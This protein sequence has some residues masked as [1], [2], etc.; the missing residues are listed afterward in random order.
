MARFTTG[1][2]FTSTQQ[3]TAEALN[4]AVN[5]AAIST[6]SVDGVTIE[7]N[8][9]AV[10]V[11]DNSITAVK[12]HDDVLDDSTGRFTA[13]GTDPGIVFHHTGNDTLSNQPIISS[14]TNDGDLT[15]SAGK[16]DAE[17]II[18]TAN[19]DASSVDTRVQVGEEVSKNNAG[20]T[21]HGIKVT[22]SVY[23]TVDI[24][25]DGD[26]VASLSSDERLKEDIK[27]IEN[28]TDKVNQLSGNTFKWKDAAQ[29]KGDDIGVIAQEV[30]KIIPSAVK[31]RYDGY[32]K[33]DYSRI[34]PLLLQSIKE[35]SQKVEALEA[36][37]HTHGQK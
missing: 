5:N 24:V 31:E 17:V 30:Q 26:V 34:V 37:S 11:K 18:A 7:I 33:V 14:N 1:T 9:N 3:V 36:K 19:N 29:Y 32:L 16:A 23:A 15:I 35:L 22:G 27:P 13:E 25:A 12:I 6:D 2:T 8:S 10:R 21:V 20:T 28:A 4:N